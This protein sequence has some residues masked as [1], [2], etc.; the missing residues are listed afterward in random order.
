MVDD[1]V[2]DQDFIAGGDAGLTGISTFKSYSRS[3]LL[4]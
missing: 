1:E 3:L 4:N 2:A